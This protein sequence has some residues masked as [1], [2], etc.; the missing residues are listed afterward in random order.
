MT[1]RLR[2]MQ[3]IEKKFEALDKEV[4]GMQRNIERL[5][6]VLI[7]LSDAIKGDTPIYPIDVERILKKE[8]VI[9]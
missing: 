3:S 6:N 8:G 1:D 5:E 7:G 2:Q 9:E 4:A